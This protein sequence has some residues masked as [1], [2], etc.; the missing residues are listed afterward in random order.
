[1]SVSE[2]RE[3]LVVGE[4]FAALSLYGQLVDRKGEASVVL[5]VPRALAT[6]ELRPFDMNGE[7][8][9]VYRDTAFHPVKEQTISSP[10]ER[11]FLKESETSPGTNSW[12]NDRTV[13]QTVGTPV[14]IQ[15][16]P[17]GEYTVHCDNGL[18]VSCRFIHWTSS[19]RE[20]ARCYAGELPSEFTRE[21]PGPLFVHYHFEGSV[22]EK[23]E[24]FFFP[25][26]YTHNQGHFIGSFRPVS[27]DGRQEAEFVTFLDMDETPEEDI[28]KKIRILDRRLGNAFPLF[29]RILHKKSIRVSSY[30]P[31][32]GVGGPFAGPER[33]SFSPHLEQ[34][35]S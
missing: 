15:G 26:S 21:T 27:V 29:K 33:I 5:L 3:H 17:S 12:E 4:G 23:A 16:N 19:P 10:W 18:T 2:T 31:L 22:T 1:M 35:D 9:L 32:P 7:E 13:E 28:S 34:P 11:Y 6:C 20:F 8:A 14:Q 25:L 24:T 30:L